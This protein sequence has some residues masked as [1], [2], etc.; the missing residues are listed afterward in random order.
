MSEPITLRIF[1]LVGSSLCVASQD[2]Q[3]VYDQI[4]VALRENQKV[5]LS[6]LNIK[7]LTSAFLNA[8]IGQVYGKFPEEQ[9]R[10][11]LSVADI[12]RDDLVLLSRVVETAKQ[13]FR[14]PRQFEAARQEILGDDDDN[15]E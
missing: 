4:A 1:E 8:A 3:Q 9:I 15:E 10:N 7:S 13:Y 11:S 14:S 6:F 2:G 12:E 5:R